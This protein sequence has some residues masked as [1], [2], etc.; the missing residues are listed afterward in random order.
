MIQLK[1]REFALNSIYYIMSEQPNCCPSCQARLN[2]IET[3]MINN[4]E[5]QINY[6]EKCNVEVLM[7]DEDVKLWKI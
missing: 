1:T 7:V 5:I 4:E 2:I 6:C 3:V